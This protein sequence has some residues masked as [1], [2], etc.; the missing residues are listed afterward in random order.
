MGRAVSTREG[1][2]DDLE[3]GAHGE[4]H[5]AGGDAPDEHPVVDERA[6]RAHLGP[7][8]AAAETVDVGLGQGLVG[9]GLEQLD[10][11]GPATPLA[12]PG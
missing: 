4:H 7:V 8:L 11:G 6:R 10:R 12:G 5:C 2:A 3:A 9:D 1:T